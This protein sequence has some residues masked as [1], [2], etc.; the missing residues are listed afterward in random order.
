M[1][2]D[3]MMEDKMMDVEERMVMVVVELII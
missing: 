1:L 2:E 3:K